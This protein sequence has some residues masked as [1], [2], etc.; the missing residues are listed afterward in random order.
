MGSR[1]STNGDKHPYERIEAWTD[2]IQG[3]PPLAEPWLKLTRPALGKIISPAEWMQNWLEE[4]S[5]R[6]KKLP[7]DQVNRKYP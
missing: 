5:K 2:G 4:Q 6:E 3:R 1:S 7:Q